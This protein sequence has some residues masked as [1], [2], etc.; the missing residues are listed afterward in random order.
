L[1]S[2]S[3]H[4]QNAVFNSSTVLIPARAASL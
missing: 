4:A 2:I 1:Y 3:A